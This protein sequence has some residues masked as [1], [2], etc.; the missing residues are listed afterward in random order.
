MRATA[1]LIA[2]LLPD[3]TATQIRDI[4]AGRE[5]QTT[6]DMLRP[7]GNPEI[8]TIASILPAE[9]TYQIVRAAAKLGFDTTDVL[10]EVANAATRSTRPPGNQPRAPHPGQSRSADATPPSVARLASTSFPRP[11]L[12]SHATPGPA[13]RPAAPTAR[14][15]PSRLA[16]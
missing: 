9:T 2:S 7:V 11:P 10:T 5:L 15:R 12:T 4:T 13:T 3:G 1:A 8:P 6:D 14:Q 16:R